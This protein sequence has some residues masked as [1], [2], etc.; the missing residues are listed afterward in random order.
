MVESYM[1]PDG[2]GSS[3]G[4]GERGPAAARGCKKIP[5]TDQGRR[6]T[7][8]EQITHFGSAFHFCNNLWI[9]FGVCPHYIVKEQEGT[10]HPSARTFALT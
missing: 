9:I 4:R 2:E 7:S 8:L 3:V 5:G 1:G 10:T 6:D